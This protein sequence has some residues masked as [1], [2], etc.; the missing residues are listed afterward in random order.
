MSIRLVLILSLALASI[1]AADDKAAAPAAS[2]GGASSGGSSSSSSSSSSKEAPKEAPKETKKEK[3]DKEEDKESKNKMKVGGGLYTTDK[4]A[5]VKSMK[6][7]RP[8]S[9][10][11]TNACLFYIW[12]IDDET[13]VTNAETSSW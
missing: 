6:G 3:S 8:V 4:V 1:Y 5:N 9:I 10:H 12:L 2:S 11:I 7:N 13:C